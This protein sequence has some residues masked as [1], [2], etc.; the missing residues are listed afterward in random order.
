MTS[1]SVTM[2]SNLGSL[3]GG[4][5]AELLTKMYPTPPS[6]ENHPNSSPCGGALSDGGGGG[7]LSSDMDMKLAVPQEPVNNVLPYPNL[8]S[9]ME[10]PIEDWSYV[11]M[12]EKRCSLVGS[13]KYAPMTDLPS[14]AL[15]PIQM[16]V[17]CAYEATWE[18]KPKVL[19]P[20]TKPQI[21]SMPGVVPVNNKE[22]ISQNPLMA[23]SLG[24]LMNIKQEPQVPGS[25][26]SGMGGGVGAP[27]CSTSASVTNPMLTAQLSRP[28][29]LQGP[30]IPG[31]S[32]M[33]PSPMHV[34]PHL[35]GMSPMGP[36]FSPNPMQHPMNQH[37][38]FRRTPLAPP[39]PYEL[40]VASPANQGPN[41]SGMVVP[42]GPGSSGNDMHMQHM[43]MQ[44][45]MMNQ[46]MMGGGPGGFQ[47]ANNCGMMG[48]NFG[49]GGMMNNSVMMMG[50][51]SMG[52]M[53][54]QHALPSNGTM[55][56]SAS[57]MMGSLPEAD[58]LL[59]NVLLYDTLL[60]I[61]RDHNFDSCTICVCNATK[62]CVGNIRGS[63]SGVYLAVRG[64]S[65]AQVTAALGNSSGDST[66]GYMDDDPI[67]CQCGFSAVVN[68]RLAHKSGLFYEDEME[69]TGMAVDPS[70]Y[71]KRSL[72]SFVLN[73]MQNLSVSKTTT[74]SDSNNNVSAMIKQ[75]PS[76][77]SRSNTPDAGGNTNSSSM[78]MDVVR[79]N[80][81]NAEQECL[82]LAIMELVRDQCT[83]LVQNSSSSIL[84]A[85][86]RY[87]NEQSSSLLLSQQQ[88]GS[89]VR[90]RSRTLVSINTL[91]YTEAHDV[92]A[93][94]LQQARLAFESSTGIGGLVPKMELDAF[95]NPLLGNHQMM[96]VNNGPLS[97]TSSIGSGSA[98]MR[99]SS[100]L[101]V[102]AGGPAAGAAVNKLSTL[103]KGGAFNV[104]K[105]PYVNAKGPRSNQD[106]IR[107][108]KSMQP[109]LQNALHKDC[110][111]RLWEPTYTVNGPLTWRQFHRLASSSTTDQ[112][113]PQPIPSIIVGHERDWLSLSPYALQYW[114]KLLL[115]P[116][117]YSRDIAYVVV[118]PDNDF[119][120]AKVKTFFKEL[121]TTYE[122]CKLGRHTPIKGWDGVFRVG[123]TMQHIAGVT[124]DSSKST[125]TSSNSSSS[126]NVADDWFATLG[127]SKVAESLRLY[128]QA[129]QSYL[130]PYFAKVPGDKTLLDPPES[131][132]WPAP[133]GPYGSN[134]SSAVNLL[135]KSLPS[136]MLPPNTPEPST[137]NEK[138]PSTP[139]SSADQEG[140]D[141]KDALNTSGVTLEPL[142]TVDTDDV[143]P[144]CIMIYI[145]EPFTCGNDS[146]ELQ[147]LACLSLLRCYSN[148]LNSVPDSVRGNI[149]FQIVSQESI[150]ELGRS[151]SQLRWSD[152]MRCLALSVFS[153]CRRFLTH[154]SNGKSLTG[155]GTAAQ[156]ELFL[157]NK[158]EKNRI[159]YKLY[160]PPYILSAKQEK[161]EKAET[162]SK[163]GREQPS[164]VLYC[165]YCLSKDQNWLL[166][167]VTDERG[168]LLETATINIDIPNRARR[169]K[170]SARLYGLQKLMDFMLGVI[171][172]TVQPWRLVVGRIG[173][174]GHGELKSWSFLLS[175][176]NLLK[177]S[178]H[179]K[180]ICKQCSLLSP[181]AVPSILSACLIAMEPDSNLR[182]MPDQFTPDE[183]FSQMSVQNPLSTPQDVSCTHIL[184]FPLSA[185]AQVWRL[186]NR[187]VGLVILNRIYSFYRVPRLRSMTRTWGSWRTTTSCRLSTRKR[188]TM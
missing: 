34:P 17:N 167:V 74:T 116:Y 136:P 66:N 51:N 124:N 48:N 158:D 78:L 126:S 103:T 59:V 23:K 110:K 128:Y 62:K 12:P 178:K 183:R 77:A 182:V 56:S 98:L 90:R 95:G 129:C 127:E 54:A 72:L 120:V 164:S 139:K 63:D 20:P 106:I 8:G 87:Q 69:I 119:V 186:I 22:N 41:F 180:E 156:M 35:R 105:W 188:T 2:N 145:V 113:E 160:T 55:A 68:R 9:P 81:D 16:S 166:A 61:F 31:P 177:A 104:H 142:S 109:I 80:C 89:V 24:G 153:Q 92:V 169:K 38:P 185:K 15:P 176:A 163:K 159:P 114:D 147:R 82:P 70:V 33:V 132:I 118:A 44:R 165:S 36:Q 174:I 58:S 40:A 86:R 152:E 162:V 53:T 125:T 85:V 146:P 151:R 7:L 73:E 47:S 13:S 157:K 21:K 117:S 130:V 131:Y 32:S 137:A 175:K 42:G 179:L 107:L 112:C 172:Q 4:S 76:F 37:M 108:M 115:E 83:T 43:Q 88:Q 138:A 14:Q 144:P 75:E 10:E 133:P 121:S 134:A 30:M 28:S 155:F 5:S 99:P 11:F 19:P 168:E 101:S 1:V 171:S 122:M 181:G 6:L 140:G 123:K 141:Q 46:Q 50:A 143:N 45:I 91:E 148:I 57:S 65:F 39:P 96:R 18:R 25:P 26:M 67:Q 49:A 60:N 161:V 102:A 3:A 84:R 29:P 187:R 154:T 27:G 173:R 184:V 135:N 64:H 93:L 79:N 150:C 71:K 100:V 52:G 97:S 149:S 94:A 111:T 170:A